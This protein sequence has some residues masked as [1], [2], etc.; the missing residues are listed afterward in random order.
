MEEIKQSNENET[1]DNSESKI[2]YANFGDRLIARFID[3]LL[4][5]IVGYLLISNIIESVETVLIPTII[6]LPGFFIY[7]I[8]YSPI[9]ESLGGTFGKKVA[10]IRTINI[11]TNKAPSIGQTFKRT[12]FILVPMFVFIFLMNMI[13]KSMSTNL[14]LDAQGHVSSSSLNQGFMAF[15]VI[16]IYILPFLAMLWSPTKQCWHDKFSKIAVIKTK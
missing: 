1:D 8:L 14:H 6:L 12:A 16:S 11:Q 15:I 2:I 3:I 7:H 10:K 5:S 4:T 13:E 9:M